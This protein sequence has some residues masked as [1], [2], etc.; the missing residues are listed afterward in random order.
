MITLKQDGMFSGCSAPR[1]QI[2]KTICGTKPTLTIQPERFSGQPILTIHHNHS[3]ITLSP[4]PIPV[5][6]T[7][8]KRKWHSFEL[9]LINA[10]TW[11]ELQCAKRTAGQAFRMEVMEE[12]QKDGRYD[13]LKAKAK[14]LQDEADSVT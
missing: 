8:H 2:E 10:K 14:R 11:H 3:R 13:W 9:A 6:V 4:A 5:S 12:W 1:M 7:P